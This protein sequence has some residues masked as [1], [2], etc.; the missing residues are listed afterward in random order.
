MNTIGLAR[1]LGWFSLG[2]GA[3]EM[4]APAFLA[5]QLGLRGRKNLVRAFGL[6]EVMAGA[7]VLAK[8]WSATGP[9]LRVAGDALDLAVLATALGSANRHR[10]AASVAMALVA[11]IAVLDVVCASGLVA[12]DRRALRTAQTG[13]IAN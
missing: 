8:P 12:A 11:G 6:R 7:V 13:R 2:L 1:I 3:L 9:G 5:R 10:G 4:A